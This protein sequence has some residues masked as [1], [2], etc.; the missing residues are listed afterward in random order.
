MYQNKGAEI[1]SKHYKLLEG[2][3]RDPPQL[4]KKLLQFGIDINKPTLIFAEVVMTYIS[5]D[6]YIHC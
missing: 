1:N 5:A 2:D 3:L 6:V 4:H